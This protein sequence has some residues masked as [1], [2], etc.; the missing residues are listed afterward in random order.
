MQTFWPQ[1]Y[2]FTKRYPQRVSMRMI[3]LA[4]PPHEKKIKPPVILCLIDLTAIFMFKELKKI[5]KSNHITPPPPRHEH[6]PLAHPNTEK[7]Y[8]FKNP[9]PLTHGFAPHSV[10]VWPGRVSRGAF[11]IH[12]VVLGVGFNPLLCDWRF[13]GRGLAPRPSS[14]WHPALPRPG[15]RANLALP[16]RPPGPQG[17]LPQVQSLLELG[18]G[19]THVETLLV[20]GV[21]RVELD[22]NGVSC[23]VDLFWRP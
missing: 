10:W 15:S 17:S 8:V 14:R 4:F 21:V 22:H 13:P 23:G 12:P 7:K 18:A 2:T 9:D 11:F 6:P 20:D 5:I 1:L 19:E 3:T 16:A